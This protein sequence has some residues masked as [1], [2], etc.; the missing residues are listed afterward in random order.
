MMLIDQNK[1]AW[2]RMLALFIL[3]GGFFASEGFLFSK[4]IFVS[5]FLYFQYKY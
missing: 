5:E 4:N 2:S 3:L 1:L